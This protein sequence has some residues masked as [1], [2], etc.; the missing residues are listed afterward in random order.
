MQALPDDVRADQW[1][2]F[3]PFRLHSR[4]RLLFRGTEPVLLTAKAFDILYFL[5]QENGRL[6]SKEELLAHI[7]PHSVVE[8]GNLARQISTLRKALGD[9]RDSHRYIVTVP[10]RGYRFVAVVREALAAESD[11]T[12][13]G[14]DARQVGPKFEPAGAPPAVSPSS[15]VISASGERELSVD[16]VAVGLGDQ[17]GPPVKGRPWLAPWSA[18]AVLVGAAVALGAP[19]LVSHVPARTMTIAV[20][21]F[22]PLVPSARDEAF[23]LGMTGS[24]I[25]RVSQVPELT[26]K[27]LASVRPFS[28]IDQDPVAAGRA[29]GV[30]AVLESY[31]HRTAHGLRVMTRL[32]RSSDGAAIWAGEWDEQGTAAL[33][34]EGSISESLVDALQLK[35]E[36]GVRA[37]IRRPYTVSVEAQERYFFGKYHLGIRQRQRTEQAEAAFRSA[38]RMDPAYAPAY[39]GLAHALIG[40][41]WQAGRPAREAMPLAKEAALEALRLDSSLAEAHAAIG[42]IQESFELDPDGAERSYQRALA[43]DDQDWLVLFNYAYFLIHRNRLDEATAINER[44]LRLDPSSA[45]AHRVRASILYVGRRY[46]ECVREARKALELDPANVTALGWLARCL[47]EQGNY[48]E[49]VDALEEQRSKARP[50]QDDQRQAARMWALY[51]AKGWR[52]YWTARLAEQQTDRQLTYQPTFQLAQIHVRL[53]QRDAAIETLE[54]LFEERHPSVVWL[55]HPSWDPLRSDPRLQSILRRTK[56]PDASG[57]ARTK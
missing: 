30:D 43:L 36:P 54:R 15:A 34:V 20:L 41:T 6:I 50:T 22:K 5:L 7:W 9:T 1:H 21:P 29:L 55:N 23:E 27:P 42:Q 19:R 33:A 2:E 18:V 39:S 37:S 10:G 16:L 51:R 24:V 3:G 8:E 48:D 13:T 49:V 52:A 28:P 44:H 57:V 26:V 31:V 40:L 25:T 14:T 35:L 47:E 12:E 4:R 46:E 11:R 38:I 32:L 45:L 53:G 56:A 17:P